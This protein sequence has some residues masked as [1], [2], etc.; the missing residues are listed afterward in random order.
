MYHSLFRT[1]SSVG[2]ILISFQ[3]FGFCLIC[4]TSTKS[5]GR[6]EG[7]AGYYECLVLIVISWKSPCSRHKEIVHLLKYWK[8]KSVSF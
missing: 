8:S 3:I 7:S 6:V 2:S 5:R 1:A 4:L